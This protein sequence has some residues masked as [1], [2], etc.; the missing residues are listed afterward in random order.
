MGRIFPEITLFFITIIFNY[1]DF[2]RN[3][4][5]YSSKKWFLEVITLFPLSFLL[6]FT[7]YILRGDKSGIFARDVAINLS[8]T[9]PVIGDRL[10]KLMFGSINS[11]NLY[12][13]FLNHALIFTI[14]M[15][16]L[17]FWH[18]KLILPN[19]D[20]LIYTLVPLLIA[21]IIFNPTIGVPADFPLDP[22][23][24][25]WFFLGVQE[26]VYEFNPFLRGIAIPFLLLISLGLYRNGKIFKITFWLTLFLYIFMTIIAGFLRGPGWCFTI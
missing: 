9:I 15:I 8:H 3:N 5:K 4:V 17:L 10:G 11:H 16:Y 20:K 25:P 22:V 7:G 6:L 24:G 26:L 2:I 18:R 14:A 12:I 19:K 1:V 23:K 21:V 13:P